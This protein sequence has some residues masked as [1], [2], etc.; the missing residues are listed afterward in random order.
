MTATPQRPIGFWCKLVDRLIDET[1]DALLREEQLT[2]R[3]W[4]VLNVLSTQV[5]SVVEINGQLT[6]F[7]GAG[8]DTVRPVLDEL[9]DRGWVGWADGRPSLTPQGSEAHGALQRAVSA[10]RQRVAA[11]IG[12]EEYQA[13]LDV[14]RR[15]AVNLGWSDVTG[16]TR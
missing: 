16:P 11:G 14:L 7:L 13:T 1:F 6:P 15:V 2:R 3:H 10:Q 9:T 8:E 12:A 4:Q 5:A